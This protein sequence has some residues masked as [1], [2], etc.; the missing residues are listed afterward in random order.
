[1]NEHPIK[2]CAG[3]NC[4]KKLMKMMKGDPR[5]YMF[6]RFVVQMHVIG[7]GPLAKH[8]DG[9]V[10]LFD[11]YC[12]GNII[13]QATCCLNVH[14]FDLQTLRLPQ[15]N[16]SLHPSPDDCFFGGAWM[17]NLYRNASFLSKSS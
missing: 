12:F 3:C 7:H 1:M 5:A 8:V 15:S 10:C 13:F 11:I 14:R 6:L 17:M 4:V 2:T 16:T 9:E